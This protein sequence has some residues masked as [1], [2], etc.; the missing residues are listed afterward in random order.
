MSE[1]PPISTGF[2]AFEHANQG[3]AG[4]I[5]AACSSTMNV[6]PTPS[7]AARIRNCTSSTTNGPSTATGSDCKEVQIVELHW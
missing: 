6:S 2:R 1:C 4:E 3:A 7:M 5:R